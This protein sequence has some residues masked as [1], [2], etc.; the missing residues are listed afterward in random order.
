MPPKNAKASSLQSSIMKMMNDN[1]EEAV[2]RRMG[3]T[4]CL[5]A[6]SR[7]VMAM[8]RLIYTTMDQMVLDYLQKK[9]AVVDE[10]YDKVEKQPTEQTGKSKVFKKDWIPQ[11]IGAPMSR[12]QAQD[13]WNFDPKECTHPGEYMRCRANRHQRWWC[14]LQRGSR[15]ERQEADPGASSSTTEVTPLPDARSLKTAVGSYPEFLPAPRSQ[16]KQGNIQLKVDEQGKIKM[17]PGAS[18]SETIPKSQALARGQAAL[19]D[20][21]LSKERKMTGL[22]S[23]RA[24]KKSQ[25]R[26]PTLQRRLQRH[27]GILH[28]PPAEVLHLPPK[29]LRLE[30]L[31]LV[32]VG[33]VGHHGCDGLLDTRHSPWARQITLSEQGSA[34]TKQVGKTTVKQ[35]L[36]SHLSHDSRPAVQPRLLCS[37]LCHLFTFY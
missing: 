30:E 12:S 19:R 29:H 36:F 34:T 15:W 33:D 7:L 6:W 35:R 9:G 16:P 2:P 17:T 24:P 11:G 25:G 13:H 1:E 31:L 21:S 18:G 32:D 5:S 26:I 4:R 8:M 28:L 14:C 22:R 3:T 20:R 23:Y 10:T 37:T 27:V